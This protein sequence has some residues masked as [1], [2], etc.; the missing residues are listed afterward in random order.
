VSVGL[1]LAAAGAVL[2]FSRKHRPEPAFDPEQFE[3]AVRDYGLEPVPVEAQSR[4]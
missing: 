2:A 4:Q 3:E 1:A